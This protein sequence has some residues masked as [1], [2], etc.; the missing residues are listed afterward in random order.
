M[1]ILLRYIALLIAF[2]TTVNTGFTQEKKLNILVISGGHGLIP[3]SFFA[4]FESFDNITYE[5]ISHPLA[6]LFFNNEFTDTYDAFVF[7]DIG[8]EITDEHK[9]D[10]L[11]M[12]DKGKGCLFL[13]HSIMSYQSWYEYEKIVGG[14]YFNE[15]I[16]EDGKEKYLPLKWELNQNINIMIADSLHPITR[17]L[18]AFEVHDET[19]KNLRISDSI[20][21]L[22]HTDNIK[23]SKNIAWTNKYG[24]SKIVYIQIGHEPLIFENS[25]Y[26]KLIHQSINWLSVN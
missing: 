21:T 16:I 22:L 4:M 11:N 1:K 24:N 6:N 25:N 9:Q 19:Y 20:H 23:N 10:F 26:M 8:R 18:Q 15:S 2:S 5:Y 13:H 14:R 7:Y 12:L 17:G 3:Q